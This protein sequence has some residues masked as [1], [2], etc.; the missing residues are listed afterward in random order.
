MATSFVG[1]MMAIRLSILAALLMAKL[2]VAAE[3]T[4]ETAILTSETL[5]SEIDPVELVGGNEITIDP[6]ENRLRALESRVFSQ[7]ICRPGCVAKDTGCPH[8]FAIAD[9]L[10]WQVERDDLGIAIL[11]PT[12]SGVPS[13][14]NPIM[15]LNYGSQGGIRT[16]IGRQCADGWIIGFTYT[17]LHSTDRQS[18]S[19]GGSQV[20]AVQSSP[21]TGLTNA[22]SVAA[23]TEFGY[24]TFDLNA[25]RWFH[26]TDSLSLLFI[27]GVRFASIDQELHVDYDGGAFVNGGIAAPT[28][29]NSFGGR[30]GNALE[31][32]LLP[33]LSLMG[34]SSV[35]LNAANIDQYRREE[36][37]GIAVIDVNRSVDALIPAAEI[38]MAAQY[39]YGAW[40][41]G[42]GY[43]WITWFGGVRPLSFSDSFNGGALASSTDNLGLHGLFLTLSASF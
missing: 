37:A 31:W 28:D 7:T 30:I 1:V 43:E 19:P 13:G 14:G 18:F 15:S 4:I 33:S 27:G 21:A 10:Y 5:T 38:S 6:F 22:D 23:R 3:P 12:G 36:N 34:S 42:V 17:H 26:P 39:S 9:Y 35:S 8:W 29:I 2:I 32:N 40:N 11:D 24:D 25:G 41:V 20:L 16:A